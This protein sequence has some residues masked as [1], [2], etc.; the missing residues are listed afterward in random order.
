[1][2][3]KLLF[4]ESNTTG[5]GMLALK[6]AV[7]WGLTP[8]FLCNKPERYLGLEETGSEVIVCDTNSIE[9]LKQTIEAN[10]AIEEI[11]GFATTSE[12][13]LEAVATL[14]TDYGLPGNPPEAMRTARNKS[15]TRQAL[16]QAGVGQPRF[17]IVKGQSDLE[18]A[19]ASVPVPCV[20][21]PADDSGS[22]DVLLCNTLEEVEQHTLKILAVTTNM[23]G[24]ATAQTV[25]IEEYVDAPEY[26]VEMFTWE[27]KT[28]C[29]GITEKSLTGFPYF[30]ES[31]HIFPAKLAP[32]VEAEIRATVS[33]ALAAV[34]VKNGATHTELKL[35]EEGAKIIEIN[36]RLAG[37]MIPEL[38]RL[39]T[40]V[41]MLEQQIRCSVDGPK[42]L[43]VAYQG[44]AGIKFIMAPEEGV[45][46]EISGVETAQNSAGV[47][48]V[49]V[50]GKPGQAVQ[51][52]Q[53]AYHRLG[54]IIVKGDT[55][56]ETTTALDTALEKIGVVL[57]AAVVKN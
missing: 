1:M 28:T 16:D 2:K 9:A 53:N 48:Q 21:K 35:T 57:E 10:V 14:A 7:S 32:E 54:S 31:R 56:E 30:V 27:G 23:R 3:K 46:R 17:A 24:Q 26:S 5:T 42:D 15:L 43:V 29:I 11:C 18:Q 4:V 34:G 33:K 44:H 49:I 55:Y 45:L 47:Q 6:K 50:T 38:I 51:P 8:I 13:Y 52:P 25:L 12:F 37:G 22:N 19:L 20:V 40:G 36:A 39:A 41:D